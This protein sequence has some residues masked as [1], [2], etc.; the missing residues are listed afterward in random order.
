MLSL[1]EITR[2]PLGEVNFY[3]PPL[4]V[5]VL[6]ELPGFANFN[7]QFEVLHCDKP[8]T[9]SVDALRAVHLKLASVLRCALGFIR[10]RADEELMVIH[11][12]GPGQGAN[13]ESGTGSRTGSAQGI[14]AAS[15][16]VK[17]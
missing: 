8:G 17:Y 11:S 9:G 5:E 16:Q 1:A 14:N 6:K 10:T 4:S 7:P 12:P 13:V 15:D 3:L 2:E